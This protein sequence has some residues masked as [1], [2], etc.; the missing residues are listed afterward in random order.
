VTT[1]LSVLCLLGLLAFVLQML[2]GAPAAFAPGGMQWGVGNRETPPELPP[3][4]AR[5]RRAHA[6]LMENLPHY[7]IVVLVAHVSGHA[8]GTTATAS[9]VYLGARIAHAI[10]YGLGITYVRTIAFYTGVAAEIVIVT[11]LF[12]S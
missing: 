6:N 8:N 3:W 5:T 2:P 9:L 1:D 4:A 11:Q 12:T 10:M 7:V